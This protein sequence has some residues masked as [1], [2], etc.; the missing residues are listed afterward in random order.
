M[1]SYFLTRTRKFCGY[2]TVGRSCYLHIKK[3]NLGGPDRRGPYFFHARAE[4]RNY[5]SHFSLIDRER[6]VLPVIVSSRIVGSACNHRGENFSRNASETRAMNFRRTRPCYSYCCHMRVSDCNILS[7]IDRKALIWGM[8]VS[9]NYWHIL[10]SEE[11][12][13]RFL[14]TNIR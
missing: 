13:I 6:T 5:F 3:W 9:L 1:Q 12:Y 10:K 7:K 2:R 11:N 14:K 4:A 8:K